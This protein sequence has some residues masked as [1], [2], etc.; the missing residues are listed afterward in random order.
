MSAATAEGILF[1]F[2]AM[3]TFVII[4]YLITYVSNSIKQYNCEHKFEHLSSKGIYFM[5][6]IKCCKKI[7]LKQYE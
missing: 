2:C 1:W 7:K 5:V 4:A 6:C 3:A